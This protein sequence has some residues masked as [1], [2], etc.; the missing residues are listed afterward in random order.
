MSRATPFAVPCQRGTEQG[1]RKN[2]LCLEVLVDVNGGCGRVAAEEVGQWGPEVIGS[3][4]GCVAEDDAGFFG[5]AE[6]RT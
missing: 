5:G 2:I 1:K 4:D 6:S 3:I